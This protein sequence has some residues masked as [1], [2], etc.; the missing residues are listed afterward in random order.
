[1]ELKNLLVRSKPEIVLL[2]E[3]ILNKK[4]KSPAFKGY[5]VARW[6]R[7]TGSGGEFLTLVKD[8]SHLRF[9]MLLSQEKA[10]LDFIYERRWN[11]QFNEGFN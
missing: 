9:Q 6:D 4:Q 8:K 7:K 2:Q 11:R 10:K 5:S 1:M 3:T